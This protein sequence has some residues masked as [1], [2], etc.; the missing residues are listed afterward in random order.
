MVAA[1]LKNK[2][3]AETQSRL[4]GSVGSALGTTGGF[5]YLV[6]NAA[7]PN[8]RIQLDPHTG[9]LV[10]VIDQTHRL[11]APAFGLPGFDELIGLGVYVED[12]DCTEP[13]TTT[14][15]TAPATSTTVESTTT[16]APVAPPSSIPDEPLTPSTTAP[17]TT[18]SG[19][20]T[21]FPT[22]TAVAAVS[23]PPEELPFTGDHSGL[24]AAVGG[25]T[26]AAGLALTLRAKHLV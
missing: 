11:N 21:L 8:C 7:W 5:M 4:P 17:A 14:S 20:P 22:T 23:T 1:S 13:T 19:G 3:P 2:D 24:I 18:V 12:D 6:P 26:L 9:P 10:T 15:T 16:T 25:A